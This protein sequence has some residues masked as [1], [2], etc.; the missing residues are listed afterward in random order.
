MGSR[1]F[2]RLHTMWCS[3]S[4]QESSRPTEGGTL[5]FKSEKELLTPRNVTTTVVYLVANYAYMGMCYDSTRKIPFI[6]FFLCRDPWGWTMPK[7]R[8]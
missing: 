6:G 7:D 5:W 4:T 3:F 8:S 2:L 1:R